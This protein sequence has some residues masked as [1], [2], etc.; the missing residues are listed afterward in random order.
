MNEFENREILRATLELLKTQM[1]YVRN[2]HEALSVL[3]AALEKD[4]PQLEENQKAEMAKIRLN[5]EQQLQLHEADELIR[6]LEKAS[7]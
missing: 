1:L 7:G 6:R 4:V 5:A 3:F 2:L